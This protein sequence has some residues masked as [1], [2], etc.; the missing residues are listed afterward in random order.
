MTQKRD[1]L[2]VTGDG[3]SRRVTE[4]VDKEWQESID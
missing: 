4:T 2:H 1:T 3:K